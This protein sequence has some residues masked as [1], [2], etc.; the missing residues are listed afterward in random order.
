MNGVAKCDYQR[1]LGFRIGNESD[2]FE[3][4]LE[5][6]LTIN[7]LNLIYESNELS[8]NLVHELNCVCLN[9]KME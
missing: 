7:S 4:S 2:Q 8:I 3:H 6:N 5:F 1:L 9:L